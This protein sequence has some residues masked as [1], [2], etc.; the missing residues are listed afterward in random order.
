M[1]PED[2]KLLEDAGWEVVC[3][4]PFELEMM[5]EDGMVMIGEAKGASAEFI[6]SALKYGHKRKRNNQN[7]S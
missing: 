1:D 7:N 3:E 5:S 2:I 6:L 4:S